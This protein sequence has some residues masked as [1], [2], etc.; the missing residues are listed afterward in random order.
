MSSW[1]IG[2]FASIDAGL[3]VAWPVIRELG[4]PTIQLHAPHADNRTPEA[5]QKFKSQLDEHGIQCTAVFGGFEGESYAD[6]PTVV[7]TVGLVPPA[8]RQA[9]LKEMME[10]SDFARV[11]GVDCVA[12]HIGFVPHDPADADY[13]GIVEVTQQLCDHCR[14]NEQFLHLETGQETADG[15]LTFIDSVERDNLKINFDP[16]NMILYGSGDPIEALRKVGSH[17]RSVHCK[18]GVWSDQPGIT[19]GREVPLGQ[20]D[21]GMETYLKTLREIGYAGPL[22][23]EREIPED[24]ARQKAEIGDAIELLTKIRGEVLA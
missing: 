21:V 12:L 16:A 24:P 8:T 14:S 22:T 18:D 23:I 10:I 19:F 1:P 4:L 15:L 5:A 7:K 6:I 11:L 2:V 20:G 3:G 13:E 9:R 17:V